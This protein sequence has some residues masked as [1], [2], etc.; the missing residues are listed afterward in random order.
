MCSSLNSRLTVLTTWPGQHAQV[1][2]DVAQTDQV[3]LD[4][5]QVQDALLTRLDEHGW[6]AA[7][8]GH[9]ERRAHR[10]LAGSGILRA[11]MIGM[12]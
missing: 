8:R 9:A 4:L 12:L 1:D 6:L 11:A 5:G 7:Q 10:G 3:R 2:Q